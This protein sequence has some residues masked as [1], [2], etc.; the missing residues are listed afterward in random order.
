VET[1]PLSFLCVIGF[2]T[3]FA[4]IAILTDTA[5]YRPSSISVV[6]ALRAPII[7]PLNNLLYNVNSDNLAIHGLHPRYQHLLVNLP[8]L[9]GPV[10][11]IV[12]ISLFL[13]SVNH[14]YLNLKNWR[15]ISAISGTMILSIFPHQETRFLIP[16]IP[17][18]LSC[19]RLPKSRLFLTSWIIFN[20]VFGFLMGIYHQGG[21]I[22]TQLKIPT[23][24]S[25]NIAER[26]DLLAHPGRGSTATIFWWK[27]YSPPL[28]LLGNN[29]SFPFDIITRDLMG[30]PGTEMI[31]E[32]ETSLPDC[33]SR[34]QPGPE[35][36]SPDSEKSKF[37]FLVAPYSATFLDLYTRSHLSPTSNFTFQELWTY[38]RHLN[39]DDLDFGNDGVLPTLKRTIG[40]RGLTVW[41]VERLGCE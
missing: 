22:P 29:N 21:V 2:G 28:W 1:S 15:T 19:I 20:T 39:L 34:R 17:L 3:F 27:T 40:R 36:K 35:A 8:Q 7:T 9:L 25:T 14:T 18:L 5:F 38:R 24:I 33:K 32:L 30:V 16:C 10:Y 13:R 6:H 31:H 4:S 26:A 11:I 12:I 37:I 41:A 23:L